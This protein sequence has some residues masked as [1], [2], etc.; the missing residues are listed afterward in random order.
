MFLENVM[1]YRNFEEWADGQW[2]EDGEPRKQAYTRDELLLI[3][4]GWNYGFDAA[5]LEQHEPVLVPPHEF[6]KQVEGKE[7]LRGFPIMMSVW[8]T[9]EEK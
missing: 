6:V 7:N 1:I 3:E 5:R 2:L 8:P 4:M 9:P